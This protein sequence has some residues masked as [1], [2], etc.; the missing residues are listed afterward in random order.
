MEQRTDDWFAARLGKITASR[1][2]DI[3]QVAGKPETAKRRNYRTELICE[4]LTGVRSESY[5]N[6]A[7]QR[8]I[9]LEPVA[10]SVF[11]MYKLVT[12]VEVGFIDHP[13][14]PMAGASPDG[15]IGDD[16]I[17]EIKCPQPNTHVETLMDGKVPTKYIPQIQWQLACTGRKVCYF[18]SYC[19]EMGNNLE[20][21][22]F[23]VPRDDTYIKMLETEVERFNNEIE[24]YLEQLKGIKHGKS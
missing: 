24:T 11:E 23:T 1:I 19:P 17:I 8:G 22:V 4:R 3:L 6:E 20:L 13:S 15:L 9:D 12:V 2:A 21:A 16:A 14:I 5:T 10:R 7:M 18:T